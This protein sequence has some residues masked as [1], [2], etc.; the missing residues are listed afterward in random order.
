MLQH[1]PQSTPPPP[2]CC[3]SSRHRSTRASSH[4]RHHRGSGASHIYAPLVERK[5]KSS[6][7]N[8]KFQTARRLPRAYSTPREL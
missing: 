4:L 3:C 6:Q 5:A 2:S 7:S 8:S 1:I